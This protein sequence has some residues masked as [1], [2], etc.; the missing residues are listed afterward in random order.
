MVSSTYHIDF[1]ENPRCIVFCRTIDH[2]NTVHR[3]L[4]AAG[5]ACRVIH[6]GLERIEATNVL[7]EFRAGKT[8]TL[9]SVDMLN[10]GIDVP[11]V[12]M[13]VFLRVTHSRR[14]FVQQLGRGLRIREGKSSVRILDFVADIRRIA[15]GLQLNKE[16]GEY[17]TQAVEK[18][19]IRFPDGQIVVFSNDKALNFFQEYLR[20]IAE[21]QDL[22]DNARLKFPPTISE[23]ENA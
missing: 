2:A 17:A 10:E 4:R 20:D 19:F 6:S 11:D 23:P 7:R 12:N 13:V 18:E 3:L 8:P 16:A 1:I 22:D 21:V 14:I 15:A 9:V 5:K